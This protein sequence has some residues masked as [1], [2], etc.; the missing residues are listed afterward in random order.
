MELKI[1]HFSDVHYGPPFQEALEPILLRQVQAEAPNLVV[2][3]G[4]LTQ[5]AKSPQ[6]QRARGFL[7]RLPK[8]YL[9]I[10]GNHDVPLYNVFDRLFRSLEKY[11][12]YIRPEV[13]MTVQ[14]DGITAVGLNSAF[15][16]TNDAGRITRSQLA[17]AEK[18]FA[19]APNPTFKLVTTH[20]HF[21]NPP[22]VHQHGLPKLLLERFAAWGVELVLTGHTHLSHVERHPA[23]PVL[24]QAATATANRW[25]K[26]A[27][28]VNSFNVI[29]VGTDAIRVQVCEFDPTQQI[30]APAERFAFDREVTQSG[31]SPK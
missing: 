26:L 21:V 29:T 5:R 22:G 28:R 1:V 13:D 11:K 31:R 14:V 4:D 6:F 7:E 17:L 23:G 20:H 3:S 12:H 10:P 24:V 25:K 16:W 15:G 8:P 27:K 9:V 19:T 18:T 2:L 30:Y